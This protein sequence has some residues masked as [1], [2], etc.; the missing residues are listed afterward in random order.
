MVETNKIRNFCIIFVIIRKT[1][2]SDR[3]LERTRTVMAREMKEQLLV[4]WI[5][6]GE[7]GLRSNVAVSLNYRAADGRD[8]LFNLIDTPEHV[9]FSM[10]FRE[11]WS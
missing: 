7:G 6:S 10:K 3:L 2:L 4:R 8:Y 1:T 9:D 5:W 11:V